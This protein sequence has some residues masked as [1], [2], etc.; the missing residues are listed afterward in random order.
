MMDNEIVA[1]FYY[2]LKNVDTNNIDFSAVAASVGDET[3][4]KASVFH[5][6]L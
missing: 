4:G 6:T 5:P 3:T 2:A 1:M